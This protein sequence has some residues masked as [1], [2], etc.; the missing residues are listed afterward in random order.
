[1]IVTTDIEDILLSVCEEF[2][3]TKMATESPTVDDKEGDGIDEEMVV[4][5][6]KDQA[7]ETYWEPCFANVNLCVP[8]FKSGFQNGPRLKELER[9]AMKKF[10]KLLTGEYDDTHYQIQKE[11]LGIEQDKGLRCH[12]VSLTL[13]FSVLNVGY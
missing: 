12:Y 3:I 1:M 4:V 13:K 11:T 5:H 6:V 8:D 9:A 2:G 7:T 10:G